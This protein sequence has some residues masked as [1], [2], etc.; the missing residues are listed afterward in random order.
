CPV[1]EA[2]AESRTVYLPPL[3]AGKE[4]QALALSKEAALGFSGQKYKGG[5]TI[6][7]A[8]PLAL[9]PVFRIV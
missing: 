7:A 2:G 9:M 8:A 1:T 5:Q 3:P 6:T 4:W